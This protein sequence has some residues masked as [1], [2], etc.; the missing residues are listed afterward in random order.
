MFFIIFIIESIFSTADEIP[1][2]I[3]AL[4]CAFFK[5]KRIFFVNV[6]SLKLR[7]SEI[8]EFKQKEN[9]NKKESITKWERINTLD[10]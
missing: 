7:N 6:S 1:I 8:R 5:S 2:R 9:F 3:W 10:C 4:S